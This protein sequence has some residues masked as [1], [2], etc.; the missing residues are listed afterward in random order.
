M[1]KLIVAHEAAVKD[2]TDSKVA[3]K[4]MLAHRGEGLR[5]GTARNTQKMIAQ[6]C[7][8]LQPR[9]HNIPDD[10]NRNLLRSIAK[11]WTALNDKTV[12]LEA[13]IEQLPFQRVPNLLDKFGIGVDTTAEALVVGDNLNASKAKPRLPSL[14][15]C[16]PSQLVR[17]RQAG[18][19]G[20]LITDAG[21][22][23]P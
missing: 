22:L 7:A 8:A 12:A 19:I 15:E 16:T 11:Y 21:S 23:T 20:S 18:G 9:G 2:R 10:A 17:A 6:H 1:R 5:Q 4:A 14:S 13:R 3:L